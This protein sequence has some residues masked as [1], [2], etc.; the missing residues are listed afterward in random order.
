MKH[1]NPLHSLILTRKYMYG[2]ASLAIKL[3]TWEFYAVYVQVLYIASYCN[4]PGIGLCSYV[5]ILSIQCVFM[6]IASYSNH[7][8]IGVTCIFMYISNYSSHPVIEVTCVSMYIATIQVL[9]CIHV[10]IHI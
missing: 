7:P 8:G 5:R 9:G 10:H 3:L 4:C 1:I 2:F 6:H